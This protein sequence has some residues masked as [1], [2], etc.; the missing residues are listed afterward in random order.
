MK[1]SSES[2]EDT[3][4]ADKH[5]GN[6]KLA[7]TTLAV[8][9]DDARYDSPP[10]KHPLKS[11]ALSHASSSCSVLDRES[12]NFNI[13]VQDMLASPPADMP[14]GFMKMF[15]KGFAG[16]EKMK[17]PSSLQTMA[18]SVTGEQGFTTK[19]KT[20]LSRQES[21]LEDLKEA[22]T[23]GGFPSK[24]KLMGR[25]MAELT[26]DEIKGYKKDPRHTAQ[27][28]YRDRWLKAK[29]EPAEHS[30]GSQK[31]LAKSTATKGRMM[32]FEMIV[33][34]EWGL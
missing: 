34:A 21:Y 3:I 32:P 4:L 8:V 22:Q 2:T 19:K 14:L 24:H 5:A 16:T 20:K 6:A 31:V 13:A 12:S 17:W 18:K 28:D 27:Q 29:K 7:D 9:R 26:P 25:M 15:E 30:L 33:R 1:S 11:T 10:P 23:V